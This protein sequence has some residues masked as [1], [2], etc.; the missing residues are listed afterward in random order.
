MTK[1]P[2]IGEGIR[3]RHGEDFFQ[4]IGA[5]GGKAKVTKGF[6]SMTPEQRREYGRKGG[7]KTKADR[8]EPQIKD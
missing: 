4:R 5:M 8:Q 7:S 1:M 3:K 6:G 2:Q